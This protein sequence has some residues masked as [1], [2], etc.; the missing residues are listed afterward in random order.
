MVSV[1]TDFGRECVAVEEKVV[2]FAYLNRI[3]MSLDN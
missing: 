3:N 1:M 2:A